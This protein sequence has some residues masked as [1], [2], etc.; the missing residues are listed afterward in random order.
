MVL[1]DGGDRD[2]NK[3]YG[4]MKGRSHRGDTSREMQDEEQAERAEADDDQGSQQGE[5]EQDK[6]KK[7]VELS[8]GETSRRD[9]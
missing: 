2:K 5:N 6:P 3:S 8:K 7:G 9:F 1:E 4:K